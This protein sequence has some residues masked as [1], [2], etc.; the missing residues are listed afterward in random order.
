M[1]LTDTSKERVVEKFRRR[2]ESMERRVLKINLDKIMAKITRRKA[3]KNL[4]TQ[5]FPYGVCEKDVGSN[6]ALCQ[7]CEMWCHQRCLV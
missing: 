4:Q 6:S 2:K 1:L 7:E 3:L 5:R